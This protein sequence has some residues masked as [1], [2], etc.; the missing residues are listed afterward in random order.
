MTGYLEGR[1]V[2]LDVSGFSHVLSF[3]K[4]YPLSH[5]D[6]KKLNSKTLK[7]FL[8][9]NILEEQTGKRSIPCPVKSCTEDA[10]IV[11][12]GGKLLAVCDQ[13]SHH[14]AEIDPD[15]LRSY[16]VNLNKLAEHFLVDFLKIKNPKLALEKENGFCCYLIDSK[17]GGFRLD[18]F[19]GKG[20]QT[21]VGCLVL[22]YLSHGDS[23]VGLCLCP[24]SDVK[25]KIEYYINVSSSGFADV[26]AI[27]E[28][29]ID[30]S[31]QIK[32][33]LQEKIKLN[34]SLAELCDYGISP[35]QSSEF[36]RKNLEAIQND[37]SF[38]YREATGS[39]HSERWK[40][41]EDL[42]KILLSGFVSASFE[43]FGGESVG[44]NLPDVAGVVLNEEGKGSKFLM[45]DPKSIRSKKKTEFKFDLMKFDSFVNYVLYAEELNKRIPHECKSLLF[46]APKFSKK[47][48]ETFS[49]RFHSKLE[50]MDI[51]CDKVYLELNAF[52][53]L[54]M[55]KIDP[56][57]RSKLKSNDPWD[58]LTNSLFFFDDYKKL[59]KGLGLEVDKTL[60]EYRAMHIDLDLVHSLTK[61]VFE[62]EPEFQS[63]FEKYYK[64]STG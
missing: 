20:K 12:F 6:I 56:L 63:T 47:N 25:N 41:F 2:V 37:P 26:L 28:L 35:V 15:K 42:M 13:N 14:R 27:D 57:T 55:L 46:I 23:Q 53:L 1:R 64:I 17:E 60:N 54:N 4:R 49:E 51:K 36:I 7:H 38:I 8:E 9:N 52:L 61:G 40:D 29:K 16:L 3:E 31:K 44:K 24:D 18:I 22:E 32:T 11:E 39:Y 43:F 5:S 33:I 59:V 34:K 45:C 62:G 48:L 50:E 19:P 10:K 21:E 30:Y 58:K